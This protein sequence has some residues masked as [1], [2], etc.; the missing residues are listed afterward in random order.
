MLL[1]ALTYYGYR[2][3]PEIR[4]ADCLHDP[5]RYDGALITV[6]TEATV[7]RVLPDGFLVRQMGRV[8]RV[9]GDAGNARPGDFV[10]FRARFH[11]EGHLTLE[12]LYVAKRRRAKVA[13]SILPALLVV[14]LVIKTYRFDPHRLCFVERKPC[15]T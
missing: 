10:R 5:A 7:E 1:V 4:L 2:A 11:R 15:R 8:V 13:V 3:F 14:A 6:G 9:I 12:Q